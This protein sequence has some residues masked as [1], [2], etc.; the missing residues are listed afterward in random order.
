VDEAPFGPLIWK[1]GALLVLDQTLL[2][3][4]AKW[5]SCATAADVAQVIAERRIRG[6]T[7]VACAAAFGVA[8]AARGQVGAGG[9]ARMMQNAVE[10]AVEQL[11]RAVPSTAHVFHALAQ[12]RDA[13][14]VS[15]ETADAAM[16]AD[17]VE[18]RAIAIHAEDLARCQRLGAHGAELIADGATVLTLG[19][20]GALAS[21]GWGTALGVL[22]SAWKACRRARVLVCETRPLRDGAR[23]TAWE[24]E[25]DGFDVTVVPD[26]AAPGILQ[27]HEAAM[28]LLGAD[29]I[30][31]DGD[32][33]GDLGA[34]G[35]AL[36][37]AAAGV[38]TVIAA[39]AACIDPAMSLDV[40]TIEPAILRAAATP[41][42]GIPERVALR[43]PAAD[44]I[45]GALIGA[46]VTE[47]GI[48][49]PPWPT[50]LR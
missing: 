19:N 26:G 6:A 35:A 4:E 17:A 18:A 10:D 12:V 43:S 37:A 38:P 16:V 45:P 29:R 33:I 21:A 8:I 3:A 13:A 39:I 49:R 14:R 47:R 24:L 34:Y 46:I 32:A 36:A 15:V 1:R 2:P 23:L 11:R 22:R 42:F 30:S 20:H 28:V 44:V 50:S 5:L 48:H 31:G 7:A 27:R 9:S 41:P 25:R 40:G